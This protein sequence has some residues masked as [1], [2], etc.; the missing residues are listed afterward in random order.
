VTVTETKTKQPDIIFREG[1]PAAVI[2]D[3]DEYQ[4]LLEQ[5]EDA[6]DLAY[7]RELRR[8]PMEF[9]SLADLLKER[10]ADV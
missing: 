3:I 5:I 1:K 9:V 2:L 7:L 6:D 10:P 4:E 8:K